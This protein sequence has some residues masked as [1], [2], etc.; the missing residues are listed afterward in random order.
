M[1]EIKLPAV[2]KTVVDEH[3]D[4]VRDLILDVNSSDSALISTSSLDG[5]EAHVVICT[6]DPVR[7]VQALVNDGFINDYYYQKLDT[8]I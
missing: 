7:I 3:L 8:L 5:W 6:A 2:S 4:R 1:F